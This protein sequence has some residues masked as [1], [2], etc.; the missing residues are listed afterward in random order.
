M[1]RSVPQVDYVDYTNR[2]LAA[3]P[4]ALLGLALA[5]LLLS[6]ILTGLPVPLGMEF[7]GGA[8]IQL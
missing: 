5:I 1:D 7:T 4:L 2:Q 8:E 6:T 3:V